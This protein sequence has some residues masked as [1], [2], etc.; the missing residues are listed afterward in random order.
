MSERD[1]VGSS[2]PAPAPERRPPVAFVFAVTATAI[3]GNT[4]L[5]PA[6][7][8][9]LH[10]FGNPDSSA[11]YI[12]AAGTI[13]GV[14]MAPVIGLLADRFG[15]RTVLVPCLV[16]FGLCGS[17]IGV[18]QSFEL[19]L[20]LRFVQ[21]FGAAGLINLAVV[22][23]G[24]HWTGLE[25]ARLVG[26]NAAVLTVSLFVFPALGGLI[27]QAAGWRWV[28]LPQF[29]ALGTAVAAFV[30]LDGG[31]TG[32]GGAV[33]GNLREAVT[34]IRRPAV[35][36]AMGF[37]F[38]FFVLVF[39]LYLTTMPIHLEE[40]FGLGPLARGLIVAAPAGGSTIAALRVGTLRRRFGGRRLVVTGT[41]IFSVA[42]V[43]IGATP[44]LWVLVL[45]TLGYGLGEGMT[46]PTVQ[47]FITG[48][49][50]DASRGS[51][52]AVFVSF[53][54]LGQTVGPLAASFTFD[55]IGTSATFV[56]A[57]VAAGALLLGELLW[58]PD[59]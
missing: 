39:G 12:V 43:L 1:P 17:L 44:F 54:R 22:I 50:T 8:N 46:I 58:R 28:F 37:A 11:G 40:E 24:D 5:L 59:N 56:V 4:L 41:A 26:Y 42:F 18:A 31:P 29:L 48:S 35:A 3:A 38:V 10:E 21:G 16:I 2:P 13:A 32:G 45:A 36:A 49:A 34:V 47:D 33:A 9:I 14:F 57:G 25:R 55:R 19:V 6:I 27:T 53:V 7:P 52:V 15:R 20:A 23:L 30:L 51:V